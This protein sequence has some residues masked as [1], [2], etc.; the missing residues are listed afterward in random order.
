MNQRRLIDAAALPVLAGLSALVAL[1]VTVA[2]QGSFVD[3]A[4]R[5]VM[6]PTRAARL[7]AAGAPAEVMLY[8]LAPDLLVGRNRVPAG[9]ALEFFPPE[10]R[11]LTLIRE[12]PSV[13]DPA[14]DRELVALKPDVYI[15][16]GTVAA[17][18]IAS[19]EAVQRRTRVPGL[20][21]NGALS[22]IPDMYRRLGTALGI[23]DRGQRLGTAAERLLTKYRGA[24][25]SSGT[26]VRV[27]IACT[28]DGYV[29]CL[30]GDSGGEQLDWLG[31]VN[32]AGTRGTAPQR[33]LTID[34]IKAMNPDLVIAG[35]PAARLRADAAW[36]TVPAVAAGRVYQWPSLPYSWGA[37]PP[38]V[39]RLPGVIWLAAVAR[40]RPFDTAFDSEVRAFF[41]DFYHLELTEP[42]L[43]KL[44]AA[45]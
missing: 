20:I 1:S 4:G 25:A 33:P 11:T 43:R 19:V 18:Y 26:P 21:L 28:A 3:D 41:K 9:D 32:V 7:F 22:R 29:P 5:A 13:D 44:L 45:S 36:Q 8:T 31:G 12:L 40:S 15:D 30:S 2:T 42:Q 35:G 38:S 16:Y 23:A 17:D 24:L 6:L 37:R 10:Y 27:Y 39:N 14:G 34:E